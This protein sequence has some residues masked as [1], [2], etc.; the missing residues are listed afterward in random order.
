MFRFLFLFRFRLYFARLTTEDDHTVELEQDDKNV[1]TSEEDHHDTEDLDF[2][3]QVEPHGQ[4][5]TVLHDQGDHHGPHLVLAAWTAGAAFFRAAVAPVLQDGPTPLPGHRRQHQTEL[6]Q[7]PAPDP[8]DEDDED[9]VA[10]DFLVLQAFEVELQDVGSHTDVD[11]E[12]LGEL[13]TCD[14]ALREKPSAEDE[15]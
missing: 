8:Q 3:H 4:E 7:A 6:Q 13:V 5:R 14:V 11:Q 9:D 1:F 10:E 12:K 2:Y 15:Q